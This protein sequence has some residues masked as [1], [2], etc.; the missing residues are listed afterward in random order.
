MRQSRLLSWVIPT[1][2]L[3]VFLLTPRHTDII[4]PS[5]AGMS[6]ALA[7][8]A[9]KPGPC[10][11][12][13]PYQVECEAHNHINA[14]AAP[15]DRVLGLSYV[16]YW[17]EPSLIQTMSSADEVTPFVACSPGPCSAE[18]FWAIYRAARPPFRFVL[19]DSTTHVLTSATFDTPPPDIK[20][21]RLF[22]GGAT[23]VYEVTVEH[24]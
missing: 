23:T 24:Q 14:V 16:R 4:S 7:A 6:V 8:V 11:G 18:A 9:E 15:G 13:R 17:L 2:V 22:A 10:S 1:A 19:H 5:F 20:I 3:T 12:S 21:R